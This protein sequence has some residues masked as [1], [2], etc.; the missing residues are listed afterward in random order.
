M[1]SWTALAPRRW[2]CDDLQFQWEGPHP[3]AKEILEEWPATAR[4][5]QIR[6]CTSSAGE[7]YAFAAEARSAQ[8][9]GCTATSDLDHGLKGTDGHE[10]AGSL[11]DLQDS[12]KLLNYI[13]AMRRIA[14][15][16]AARPCSHNCLHDS[17]MQSKLWARFP[18][19]KL[20]QAAPGPTQ[21]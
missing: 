12:H 19:V 6:T 11:W 14:A 7:G 8:P 16:A 20:N 10:T 2:C 18:E 15:G 1:L 17:R 9:P 21:A 3:D 4:S 5:H 13:F